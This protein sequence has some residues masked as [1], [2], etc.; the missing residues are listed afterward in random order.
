M[1]SARNSQATV[2]VSIEGGSGGLTTG[3]R[4][5]MPEVCARFKVDGKYDGN[6]EKRVWIKMGASEEGA[7][8]ECVLRKLDTVEAV[9]HETETGVG[10]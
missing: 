3:V 9:N 2:V 5:E 7:G 4:G 10:I 1:S 8:P 6:C